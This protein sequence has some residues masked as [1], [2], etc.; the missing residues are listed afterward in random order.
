MNEASIFAGISSLAAVLALLYSIKKYQN[1]NNQQ[2]KNLIINDL[3]NIYKESQL[4]Y[5]QLLRYR[6][7]IVDNKENDMIAT[8]TIIT[9]I[10]SIDQY[11]FSLRGCILFDSSFPISSWRVHI[12]WGKALKERDKYVN[13]I[14]NKEYATTKEIYPIINVMEWVLVSAMGILQNIS[15]RTPLVLRKWSDTEKREYY[16][17]NNKHKIIEEPPINELLKSYI[18]ISETYT[19]AKYCISDNLAHKT[20]LIIDSYFPNG[21]N[22]YMNFIHNKKPTTSITIGHRGL[23]DLYDKLK[24]VQEHQ[25][26]ESR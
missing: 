6:T 4:H 12:E 20:A 7:L 18:A 3:S 17:L 25:S 21:K 1:E 11:V 22:Y 8:N 5:S 2:F 16:K 19:K 13:I 26:K 9:L 14:R 23:D 24:A 15:N 10:S